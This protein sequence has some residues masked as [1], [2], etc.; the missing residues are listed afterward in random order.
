MLLRLTNC[1]RCD[2]QSRDD[3]SEDRHFSF[4]EVTVG[5]DLSAG[6][7]RRVEVETVL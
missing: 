5:R 3:V 4:F 7:A 1:S 2:G 6:G